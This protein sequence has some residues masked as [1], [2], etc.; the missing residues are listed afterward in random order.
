MTNTES[1]NNICLCLS[2]NK[3]L[4]EYIIEKKTGFW[5]NLVS[6]KIEEI[7]SNH[8]SNIGFVDLLTEDEEKCHYL[9]EIKSSEDVIMADFMKVIR[10]IKRYGFLLKTK[11]YESF[12]IYKMKNYFL[13]GPIVT[14]FENNSIHVIEY[15]SILEEF[16]DFM[17]NG[18]NSHREHERYTWEDADLEDT[19][20]K[21]LYWDCVT[22]AQFDDS[23][24]G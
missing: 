21:D 18:G 24:N 4:L 11:N 10:Q 22:N 19:S 14:A 15:N 1:H 3:T 20:K 2:Q 5:V 12:L 9:F 6:I 16:N 23:F 7:I 13:E 8:P 17:E